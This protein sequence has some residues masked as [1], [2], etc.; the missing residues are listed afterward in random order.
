MHVPALDEKLEIVHSLAKWKR[1]FLADLGFTAGE[2]IVVHMK[3]LRPEEDLS[4]P[5]HSIFVDQ[6][7]WERVIP[8]HTR[9]FEAL[10]EAAVSVYDALLE[11]V[12]AAEQFGVVAPQLPAQLT[13]MSTEE[14]LAQYPEMHAKER[15]H[16]IAEKYGAVFIHGIG[17]SLS[18]GQ[19]HDVRAPDYDDWQLNGDLVVWN[20]V[21]GKSLEL[22]SMGVR[23]DA[24]ALTHQLQVSKRSHFLSYPW[25]QRLLRGDLPTTVGGGIGQ[26]RVCMWLLQEPHIGRVQRSVWPR[27]IKES[28]A[29]W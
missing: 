17:G 1:E 29:L 14:L 15:E 2:G 25:H 5:V 23:V 9:G 24:Q 28:L 16:C 22:S 21:L 3:A 26:S 20:P 12:R 19:P 11:T 6:W 13:F 18:H 4:S 7:D 8:E 10:R 27:E